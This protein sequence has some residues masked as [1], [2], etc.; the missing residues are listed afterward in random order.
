MRNK[1]VGTAGDDGSEKGA[2]MLSMDEAMR[3]SR[4]LKRG[5]PHRRV[6]MTATAVSE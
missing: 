5:K 3:L 6:P 2:K 1:K 4:K